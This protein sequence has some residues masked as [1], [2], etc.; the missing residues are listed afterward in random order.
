MLDFN[1]I[2][3]VATV[4]VPIAGGVLGVVHAK[5]AEIAKKVT[6]LDKKAALYE[7]GVNDLKILITTRF[8]SSDQR[9]ERVERRVLNGDYHRE[10]HQPADRS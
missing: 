4:L 2:V 3:N 10:S 1:Q 9:L 5:H 6:E 7:Q 8:D